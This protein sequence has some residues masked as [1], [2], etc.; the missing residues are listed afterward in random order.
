MS[1]VDRSVKKLG[2]G[3]HYGAVFHKHRTDAAVIS[4]SVYDQSMCLPEHS[5]ELG[6]FTL[7]LD[8]HYSEILS[9]KTVV[10][11]PKTVLWRQAGLS[12]R[13]KIEAASSR[14]F[15][16][17]INRSFVERL[18]QCER[19]PDHL[20]EKNGLLTTL[21]SRL[22][23]EVIASDISSPLI[24]DGITLEMLGLLARRGRLVERHPPIW[25]K[26]V[27]DRLNEDI[28]A[29]VTT[30]ELAAEAG[31]HPVY[32]ASVFRKFH[33]QTIGDY[34]QKLRVA[35][36]TSL[37]EDKELPLCDIAYQCGFADQSHFTR[38]FKRRAGVTPGAYRSS[39][40]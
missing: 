22:R 30:N 35:H 4:E 18:A 20:A 5:H 32:L 31:V 11:S 13:D 12:H 17:E 29:E 19:L 33:H 23:S 16:V 27:L 7:I 26:R 34:V 39:L 25:L 36:A 10:Y 28:A 40:S 9:R 37:L 38:V 21:S 8:G 15:F 14:F 1:K 2:A 24:I 6:F 3:E